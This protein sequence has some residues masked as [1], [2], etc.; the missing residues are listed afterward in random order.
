MT[1]VD[2]KISNIKDRSDKLRLYINTKR[3]NSKKNF[4]TKLG[5]I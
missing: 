1:K 5:N 2:Y 3:G 4:D